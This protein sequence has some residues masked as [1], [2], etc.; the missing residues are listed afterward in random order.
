MRL[1]L[2]GT[3]VLLAA[4]A[5]GLLELLMLQRSRLGPWTTR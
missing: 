3:R 5:A 1:T 4:W 2:R